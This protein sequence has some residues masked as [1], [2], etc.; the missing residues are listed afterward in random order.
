MEYLAANNY[1]IIPLAELIDSIKQ[2]QPLPD[3]TVVITIDDGYRSVYLNAWPIL[4]SF[5]FPFT[6]FINAKSIDANHS[7]YMNWAEILEM[8]KGGVDIQDHSYS[9][10]HMIDRPAGAVDEEY[11]RWLLEDLGRN[12]ARIY[13]K[14]GK[15]S[16]FFAI[17]YGEYN[18]QV[19]QAARQLGYEAV[20]TQDP[21]SISQATDLF[22]IP[23]EPILGIDWASAAHFKD[24]LQRIDLP[25][26]DFYPPYGEVGEGPT[27]FG[28]R[29]IYPDRYK[30]ASFKIYVSEFGWLDAKLEGNVLTSLDKKILSRKLNRVMIKAQEKISNRTAVR[31]WLLVRQQTDLRNNTKPTPD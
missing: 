20:F 18:Q 27:T 7:N 11:Q 24:I 26:T 16:R 15:K 8:D 17:P 12:S 5:G 31:S 13:E 10:P 29:I 30:P 4:K 9:H 6:V 19:I 28:A 23:R 2:Q 21:G 3:K 22:I 14:T 1:Q 25:I